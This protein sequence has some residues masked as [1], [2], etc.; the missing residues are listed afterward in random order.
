MVTAAQLSSAK[1]AF[2]RLPQTV[3]TPLISQ[4]A[5]AAS[6]EKSTPTPW[7]PRFRIIPRNS[8][9]PQPTSRIRPFAPLRSID[10]CTNRT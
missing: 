8:P 6:I 3:G 2:E 5:V 4:A 10:F 9:P 7:N 1:G